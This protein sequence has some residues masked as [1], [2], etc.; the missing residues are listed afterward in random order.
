MSL[1]KITYVDGKTIISA[2]NLNAIQ[3]AIID[4]ENKPTPEG[5]V[6]MEQVNAVIDEKIGNAIGGSY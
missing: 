1:N 3:D 5:G 6:T 4:L 2:S